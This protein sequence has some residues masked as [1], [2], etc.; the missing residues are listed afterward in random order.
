MYHKVR[1]TL[2]A[3]SVALAMLGAGYGI[4]APPSAY[5]TADFQTGINLSTQAD[6]VEDAD[7]LARKRI[8]GVQRHMAMPFFSF[9]PLLPKQGG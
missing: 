7:L 8:L 3:A 4:G 1:N 9:A 5:D 6:A 2:V